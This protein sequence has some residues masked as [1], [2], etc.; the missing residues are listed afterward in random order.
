MDHNAI[1]LA[2][3]FDYARTGTLADFCERV[4]E[5][6]RENASDKRYRVHW[7]AA[8]TDYKSAKVTY[9]G[10]S[11]FVHH[12]YAGMMEGGWHEVTRA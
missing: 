11:Y 7:R 10:V 4:D 12:H 3:A 6:V 9:R 2:R 8:S 5:Y 1:M